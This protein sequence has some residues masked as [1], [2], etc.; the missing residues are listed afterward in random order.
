MPPRTPSPP[1]TVPFYDKSPEEKRGARRTLRLR[2]LKL[3]DSQ[4]MTVMALRLSLE[5][6]TAGAL[7]ATLEDL[8]AAGEIA[9]IG[10]GAYTK[11]PW[12]P[13]MRP[14][15][16]A[17]L[18]DTVHGALVHL[19]RKTRRKSCSVTAVSGFLGLS[20][21]D[22]ASSLQQIEIAGQASFDDATGEWRPVGTVTIR[23]ARKGID[24]GIPPIPTPRH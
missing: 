10:H 14:V 2:L 7:V 18:R 23:R 20:I 21:E 19:A 17:P 13:E 1:P 4:P 5:P 12:G 6:D 15:V 11:V 8:V 16:A 22:V 24:E 9:A 3:L